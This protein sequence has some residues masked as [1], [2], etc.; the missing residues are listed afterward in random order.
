MSKPSHHIFIYTINDPLDTPRGSCRE[1]NAMALMRKMGMA[2]EQKGLFGQ[3]LI[4]NTSFMGPCSMGPVM[5]VYP[6]GAW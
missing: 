5:I 1:N 6:D 2:I 3:I 4:T